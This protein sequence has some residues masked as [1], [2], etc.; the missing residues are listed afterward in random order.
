[1]TIPL[2]PPVW[3]RGLTE[4]ALQFWPSL[5]GPWQ[6]QD[7]PRPSDEELEPPKLFRIFKRPGWV[8]RE[9]H[10]IQD[11]NYNVTLKEGD[12]VI[13]WLQ[14]AIRR[15]FA[16]RTPQWAVVAKLAELIPDAWADPL[17][18]AA[19][20]E[21]E[22]FA[23]FL[24]EAAQVKNRKQLFREKRSRLVVFGRGTRSWQPKRV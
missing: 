4:E 5:R 14:N 11:F 17:G 15:V 23:K 10:E 22:P 2:P 18:S 1:M 16:Q 8:E 19:Y 3:T 20:G 24:F 12:D 6:G 7:Y 21:F 9:N 13:F